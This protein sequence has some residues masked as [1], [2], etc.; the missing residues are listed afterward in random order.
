MEG[1]VGISARS[2]GEAN[3]QV[4]MEH[5]GGGGHQ[6]VAGAQIKNAEVDDI[7]NELADYTIKYL[8]EIESAD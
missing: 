2:S 8:K 1:G 3:V 4:V 5:F 7:A 6:T